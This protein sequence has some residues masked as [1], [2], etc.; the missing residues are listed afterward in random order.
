M[1]QVGG[2]DRKTKVDVGGIQF[3]GVLWGW[4]T[5]V[6]GAVRNLRSSLAV[7]ALEEKLRDGLSGQEG[8]RLRD[9]EIKEHPWVTTRRSHLSFSFSPS[10]SV[11]IVRAREKQREREYLLLLSCRIRPSID[12]ET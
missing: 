8:V 2:G 9:L 3:S 5:R 1:L 11:F 12:Q 6:G 7:R 10:L 4:G